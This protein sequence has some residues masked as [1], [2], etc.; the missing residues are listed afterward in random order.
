MVKCWLAH[1]PWFDCAHQPWFDCAHQPWFDCA[2]QPWFDCAH[3]PWFDYAHQPWFGR[4]T[5]RMGGGRLLKKT[6]ILGLDPGIYKKPFCC[7]I[8]NYSRPSNE[9]FLAKKPMFAL[10]TWLNRF[11]QKLRLQENMLLFLQRF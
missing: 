1:Q 4:L 5:N 9:T 2:H 3:Q 10:T 6:V 11:L 7:V 8:I